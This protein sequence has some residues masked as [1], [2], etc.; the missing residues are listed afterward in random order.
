MIRDRYDPLDLFALIP[1]LTLAMDPVLARI[2]QLLDD[3]AIV[4]RVKADMQQRYRH[5]ACKGRSSTPVEVVL[6]LLVV[7]RLY[8][9]SYADTEHCVA[10]SL[11][12]R[13][14]CRVYAQPVPDRSTIIRWAACIRPTTLDALV[15][16][17]VTLATE[18]GVTRGR[19]LRLDTTVVETT[20]HY[21]SDSSLL[22]D[23]VRLLSRW[24]GRARRL[25]DG[26]AALCR[27]RTRSASRAARQIGESTRRRGETGTLLRRAAYRRLLGITRAMLTQAEAVAARLTDEAGSRVRAAL[28][29][30][31]GLTRRVVQQTERRLAGESVPA[32][33][34]VVSLFESHTA[35]LRRDKPRIQTEFGHKVVIDEVEGGIITRCQRLAGNAADAEQLVPALAAHQQQF[36]RA[37]GLVAT[38]RGFWA[39]DCEAVA[40]AAGVQRVAIPQ[41][42]GRVSAARRAI[43]RQRWFRRA[44]RFRAGGEGRISVWKRRGHL[45]RCP[46]HGEAGFDRWIGWG[47]ITNNLQAMAAHEV[48][49]A[50]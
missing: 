3:P 42:G 22:A 35:I 8:H 46:D 9:W 15:A 32:A 4:T 7:R 36:G 48:A 31:S 29:Q 11:V 25:I 26:P 10:D 34:K 18:R 16:R 28:A 2:D 33:Q 39:A 13:Q 17:L 1:A 50:A 20:M 30:V 47:T 12:L 5:S 14:F 45:G 38:D 37:P 21:P 44:Q 41:S 49:R 40:Q 24:V 6:R 23:G 43:E 19:K 27:N